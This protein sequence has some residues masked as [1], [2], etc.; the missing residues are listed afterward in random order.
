MASIMFITSNINFLGYILS[1]EHIPE[2]LATI[3][4]KTVGSPTGFLIVT[5]LILFVAGMI[6]AGSSC[7]LLLAPLLFPISQV[8]GIDPVYYGAIFVAVLAIGMI[9]P[10]VAATLYVA[11]R[12]CKIDMSKIIGQILPYVLIQS[13]GLALCIVFP[14]IVTFLVNL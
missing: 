4:L 1:R 12:I 13:I 7:I 8:F 2:T 10:P 14:Q 5:C 3:A 11:Q 6:E 9:T